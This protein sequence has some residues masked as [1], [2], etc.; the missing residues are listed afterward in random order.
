[1]SRTALFSLMIT[2]WCLATSTQAQGVK[3]PQPPVRAAAAPAGPKP[4]G[5][6]GQAVRITE[7]VRPAYII[8]PIVNRIE[9][10]RGKILLLEWG[11]ICE[12]A[13]STLEIF[14][15][16]L[17]Q[18]ENGTIFPNEKVP[19]PTDLE[20]LTP[21]KVDLKFQEKF[22]IKGRLRVPDTNSTF[23]TF[24]IIVRDSGQLKSKPNEAKP[25]GPRVGVKFVTQY[26]LRCDITV[27]GVRAESAGK[28]KIESGELVEV[29]GVPL[30]RVYVSNPTEGPIEFGLRAQIRLTQES[31]DNPTFP[32]GMPVRANLDEPEKYVGRILSGARLRMESPLPKPIFPGQYYIEASVL[33]DNRVLSETGFP[34]VVT[35]GEFPAQGIASVQAAPG[36]LVSPSQIEL[37]LQRGGSRAEV[38]TLQND[39]SVATEVE[40]LP[41]ALDGQPID[42]VGVRPN[43]VT[44]APGVSRKVSVTLAASGDPN[45]HRYAKLHVKSTPAGGASVESS[46][47]VVALLGRSTSLP[48]LEA[49]ELISNSSTGH[50]AFVI[51]VKN[52]GQRHMPCEALLT[53]GDESGRPIDI[54]GGFGKWVLPGTSERIR[55][56]P[57]KSLPAG[58]YS[59]RLLIPTGDGSDPIEK[60]LE[61]DMTGYQP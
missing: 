58:K 17:T 37:S 29:D 9:A 23:H 6:A 55:F 25:D 14:P 53:L 33:G 13:P 61:L 51:D 26:L 12:G 1:M 34:I 31:D 42:W 38:L 60:R 2:A 3:T 22:I 21:G 49:G 44:L 28:L 4:A 32:L 52:I 36:L 39:S 35:E 41:Q 50:P 46:P 10:R 47:I 48:T 59:A 56:N 5:Q 16:A 30:A 54:R 40:I 8:D 18:D 57:P 45:T 43:K 19:A 20:I 27:Q 24:G 15:V 7:Q 11:I